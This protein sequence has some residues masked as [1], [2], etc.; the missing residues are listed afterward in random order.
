MFKP[1][2]SGTES[3][4][5]V[6]D[7]DQPLTQADLDD[8]ILRLGKTSPTPADAMRFGMLSMRL[9]I[10]DQD[11]PKLVLR[12]FMI[13]KSESAE[14]ALQQFSKVPLELLRQMKAHAAKIASN[15]VMLASFLA[16]LAPFYKVDAT[17]PSDKGS[18]LVL[19]PTFLNGPP[20]CA[21]CGCIETESCKLK[22]CARCRSVRY[23]SVDHQRAD[24]PVHQKV[25]KEWAKQG[26]K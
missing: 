21:H 19:K 24:W 15:P 26:Q 16:E 2:K 1:S 25:C 7:S 22:F 9:K 20:P 17:A 13:D 8:Y 10:Q 23:C 6:M 18:Y 14:A 4:Q 11:F 5:S 3:F 12:R